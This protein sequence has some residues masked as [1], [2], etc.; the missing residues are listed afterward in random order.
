LINRYGLKGAF[1]SVKTRLDYRDPT[2]GG[3]YG[4]KWEGRIILLVVALLF[5]LPIFG[6]VIEELIELLK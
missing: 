3:D 1:Q 4:D 2:L 6:T 5:G